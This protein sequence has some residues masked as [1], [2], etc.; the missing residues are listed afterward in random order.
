WRHSRIGWRV[1]DNKAAPRT[2]DGLRTGQTR[3]GNAK[4]R[5]ARHEGQAASDERTRAKRADAEMAS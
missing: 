4:S 5:P 2:G 1:Y 3:E